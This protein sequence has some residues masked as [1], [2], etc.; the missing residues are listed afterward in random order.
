MT[1]VAISEVAQSADTSRRKFLVRATSALGAV[2]AVGFGCEAEPARLDNLLAVRAL[3]G[4]QQLLDRLLSE[5]DLRQPRPVRH[6]LQLGARCLGAVSG[7]VAPALL[8][9]TAHGGLD[10]DAE[11]C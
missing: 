5:L 6:A 10:V 11:S 7:V 8:A 2:G 4:A 3:D 1:G 9:A